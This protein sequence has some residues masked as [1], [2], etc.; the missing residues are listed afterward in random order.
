VFLVH[1]NVFDRDFP[2]VNF[3]VG[4]R[5]RPGSR[6][7]RRAGCAILLPS[8]NRSSAVRRHHKMKTR[9]LGD[10]N[11]EVSAVGFG[12]MGLNFS[13]ATSITKSEGIALIRAAAD[14][15]GL[16]SLSDRRNVH[17]TS[18]SRIRSTSLSVISSLV[19]S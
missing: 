2:F 8:L 1:P 14:R 10:S 5:G 17:N 7:P 11:L 9:K 6:E 19:R 15:A 3:P 18:H 16:S 13:Y 4:T 12:C